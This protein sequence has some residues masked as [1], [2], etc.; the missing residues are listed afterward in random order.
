MLS[1]KYSAE[2]MEIIDD[3]GNGKPIIRETYIRDFIEVVRRRRVNQAVIIKN[4]QVR[5]RQI[6]I[7][8]RADRIAAKVGHKFHWWNCGDD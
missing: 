6:R 2:A 4:V 5:S 3:D 7:D 1:E 8:G